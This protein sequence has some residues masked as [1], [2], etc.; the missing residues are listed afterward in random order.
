MVIIS[1]T[2]RTVS[3][4]R[5]QLDI[6]RRC[7]RHAGGGDARGDTDSSLRGDVAGDHDEQQPHGECEDAG[8]GHHPLSAETLHEQGGSRWGRRHI[9]LSA[10][11]Y[12]DN[13]ESEI[14]RNGA[15]ALKVSERDRRFRV[16]K[17]AS[18]YRTA[19][20]D[21]ETLPRV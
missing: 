9:F 21:I 3:G 20:R 6:Q 13:Q 7:G 18:D 17:E 16:Y 2:K 8:G 4:V 14:S 19:P 10:P 12:Q 15:V 11:V 1:R 5:T